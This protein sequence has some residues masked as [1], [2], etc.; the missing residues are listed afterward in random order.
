MNRIKPVCLII[1]DG[2]GVAPDDPK[3]A[4]AKANTPNLDR[5]VSAYPNTLLR[6]EGLDAQN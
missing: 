5:F 4:L 1:M 3:N 2:W 6:A